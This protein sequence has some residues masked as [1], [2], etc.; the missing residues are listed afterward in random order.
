MILDENN[1]PYNLLMTKVDLGYGGYAKYVFYIMQIILDK[2]S[3]V[4]ILFTRWGRIG[5]TGQMQH[6]PFP[7]KEAAV[8]E[9]S[10]IFSQKSGNEWTNRHQFKKQEQKY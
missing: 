6:T 3:G 2:N 10:K 5:S 8:K 7:T 1:E 9:F 4:F